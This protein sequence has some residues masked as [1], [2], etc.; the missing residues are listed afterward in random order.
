MSFTFNAGNKQKLYQKKF[1]LEI[2]S[3]LSGGFHKKH[4][5]CR[6][7]ERVRKEGKKDAQLILYHF[8]FLETFLLV[9]KILDG[10]IF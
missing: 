7:E 3:D 2:L 9:I 6:I 4:F 8:N 10:G 5:Y 1:F